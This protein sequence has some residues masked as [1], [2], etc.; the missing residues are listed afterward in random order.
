MALFVFSIGVALTVS[1][2]C[3]LMEAT[4]LSLTP[5][6]VAGLATRYPVVGTIWQK[7][8]ANIER[9]IAAILILNTA[10]HTIGASI[11]GAEFD[12]LFG[13][14][15]ILLFS[16]AFTFAMLQYTEILPKTLGVHFNQK[17]ALWIARPLF[18]LIWFFTPVIYTL[19]LLN[20]PFERRRPERRHP[21]TLEEITAL[22]AMARISRDIDPRQERIIKSAAKLSE[23][24]AR[25]VMIPMEEIAVL[26]SSQSLAEALVAAHAE[27]HT[28]FPV[29]DAGHRDRVIGYINFKELIFFM[30]TNPNEPSLRGVIRPVHFVEPEAPAAALLDAFIGRHEHLA[31]VREPDGRCV[32]MIT[33]EDIVEELV[34]EVQDEFDRLPHH[35]HELPGGTWMFG[36]GVSMTE[37]RLRLGGG[38]AAAE[39]LAGWLGR[40]LAQP[41]K[42]GQT[43]RKDG[44]EFTVRRVRRGK[45]FEVSA[46]K[47]GE[48]PGDS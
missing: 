46:M 21:A 23:T 1:F 14:R 8:K 9:P 24:R 20:R 6:Q 26:S 47:R 28:R 45:A 15:W 27:A 36:G 10:A 41:P 48:G 40:E 25:Q 37:V 38:P 22:A 12:Q 29:C 2:L 35:V 4:L 3:S 32:G 16:L 18:F 7:F 5:S 30:R 11:A 39:T 42:P 31:I 43:L 19:H 17:L 34:G 13:D 33:L 44:V